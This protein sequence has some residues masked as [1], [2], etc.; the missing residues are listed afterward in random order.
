MDALITIQRKWIDS[1]IHTK[2]LINY[3]KRCLG[4]LVCL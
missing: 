2:I 3:L 1:V 4:L